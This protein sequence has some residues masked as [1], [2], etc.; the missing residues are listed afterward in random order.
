MLAYQRVTDLLKCGNDP[1]NSSSP[2]LSTVWVI[3]RRQVSVLLA[4][5]AVGLMMPLKPTAATRKGLECPQLF[6]P[7]RIFQLLVKHFARHD[8][9]VAELYFH[10]RRPV[11]HTDSMYHICTIY[12]F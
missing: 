1:W 9:K 11:R 6:N 12:P 2:Q 10:L 3:A 8:Q 4:T 5:V 7:S